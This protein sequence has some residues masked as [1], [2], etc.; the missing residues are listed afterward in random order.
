MT[1][2]IGSYCDS[3]GK[4]HQINKLVCDDCNIVFP[5]EE[6]KPDH[7]IGSLDFRI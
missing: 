5:N 3:N 7:S 1:G 4:F 2:T 6:L